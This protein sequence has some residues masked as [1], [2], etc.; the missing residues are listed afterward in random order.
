MT[1]KEKLLLVL[2]KVK[3]PENTKEFV[4]QNI[5]KI[6]LDQLESILKKYLD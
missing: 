4:L 2:E 1:Q 5:D 6:N 3:I